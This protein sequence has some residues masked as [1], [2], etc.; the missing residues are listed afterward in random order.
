MTLGSSKSDA[1]TI[2]GKL[3]I[4]RFDAKISSL[5]GG[6]RKRVALAEALIHPAD[7][8]IL[9]EPTNHIDN[10]TVDWLEQ[11]LNKRRGALLMITH[12][13][14]FLDRVA[15][16]MLELDRGKL[17]SPIIWLLE[18][19]NKSVRQR[20]LPAGKHSLTVI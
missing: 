20:L 9:D 19:M 3:G 10:E 5:S 2:L 11:F 14:Y 8:L 15:N 4:D 16:R 18:F 13:R 1:K 6:Q 17:H 7:L 12:D